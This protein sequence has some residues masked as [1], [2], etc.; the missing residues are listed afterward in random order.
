MRSYT[1]QVGGREW[2]RTEDAFGPEWQEAKA[3]AAEQHKPVY[4]L[5]YKDEEWKQEVF[6]GGCFLRVD[7][8]E[9]NNIKPMVF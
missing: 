7:L 5:A 8:A 2:P 4:R 1:Y 6:V 3:Y 9:K